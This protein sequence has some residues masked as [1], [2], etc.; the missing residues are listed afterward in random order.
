MNRLELIRRKY[1]VP[2]HL[3]RAV[4][5]DGRRGRIIGAV[6][7]RLK[8]KIGPR[9][10]NGE[11]LLV[12]PAAPSLEYE[13]RERGGTLAE[14]LTALPSFFAGPGIPDAKKKGASAPTTPAPRNT[15]R[16]ETIPG[17]GRENK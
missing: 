12:E 14:T 9:A 8:I 2:A 1:G 4:Y 13:A 3:R 10:G 17:F 11:I 7:Q 5:V 6:G 15:R 16:Q